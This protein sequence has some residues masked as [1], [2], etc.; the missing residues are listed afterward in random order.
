MKVYEKYKLTDPLKRKAVQREI[1]VLKKVDHSNIIKMYE[2]IDTPKHINL[3]T[4]Y[5][6][7]ISLY[8]YCKNINPQR[9][10]PET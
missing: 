7:G 1:A 2:L 10:I 4:E 3:V 9:R 5:V 8:N 6:N